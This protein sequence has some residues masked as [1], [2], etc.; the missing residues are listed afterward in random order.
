MPLLLSPAS[1]AASAHAVLYPSVLPSIHPTLPVTLGHNS[2]GGDRMTAHQNSH[3]ETVK[4][5][6]DITAE[7]LLEPFL[8]EVT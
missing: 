4:S 8:N 3:P 5:H 7:T 1:S 2:L 6:S